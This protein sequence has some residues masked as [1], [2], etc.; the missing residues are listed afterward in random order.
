MGVT[1]I[2]LGREDLFF[3]SSC[4]SLTSFLYWGIFPEREGGS[5]LLFYVSPMVYPSHYA[6]GFGGFKNPAEYPYE[7]IFKSMSR[8]IEKLKAMGEDAKKFRPWIQD[9]DLGTNYGIAEVN[10]Q[11]QALYDLG[12]QSWMAWDPSNNYTKPAY[13]H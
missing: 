10:K 3:S 2:P 4:F 6:S 12:I 5:Q 13:K 9:F 11:K 7:V 8:G 1:C